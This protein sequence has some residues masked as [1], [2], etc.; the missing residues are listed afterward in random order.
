MDLYVGITM[1]VK[2]ST[3]IMGLI[4]GY[5]NEC[6]KINDYYGTYMWILHI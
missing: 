2:K 5:C 4:C 3:T 1:N 6:K